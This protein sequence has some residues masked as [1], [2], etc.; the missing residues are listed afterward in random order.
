M[1]NGAPPQPARHQLIQPRVT[2]M[3]N[4]H[5]VRLN[6][7]QRQSRTRPNAAPFAHHMAKTRAHRPNH[8]RP[9]LQRRAYRYQ[10]PATKN[11]LHR[12]RSSD[13]A[14]SNATNTI[15]NHR[16]RATAAITVLVARPRQTNRTRPTPTH[17]LASTHDG[18]PR[19]SRSLI[20][21]KCPRTETLVCSTVNRRP[22]RGNRRQRN[23]PSA[24]PTVRSRCYPKRRRFRRRALHER[25]PPALTATK[26]PLGTSN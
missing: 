16:Q 11:L 18:P 7:S 25:Q 6:R 17:H 13:S 10:R 24:H 1:V 3:S 8:A 22:A 5:T 12:N 26:L 2:H 4:H 14:A 21:D 19:E 9:H 15:S 23:S 20:R